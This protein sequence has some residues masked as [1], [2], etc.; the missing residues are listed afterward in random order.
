MKT[1]AA[2]RFGQVNA[3]YFV[4]ALCLTGKVTFEWTIPLR[5]SGLVRPLLV[6]CSVSG[7]RVRIAG[8]DRTGGTGSSRPGGGGES[9]CWRPRGCSA[10]RQVMIVQGG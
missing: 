4:V 6:P 7:E 8:S 3:D 5:P 10:G 9:W 2:F 1:N